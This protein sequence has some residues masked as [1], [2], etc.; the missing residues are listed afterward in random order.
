M[1][2]IAE[3]AEGAGI[4]PDEIDLYGRYK[5]KIHLA[6]L[7]R[8]ADKPDGNLILVTGITPTTKGE[9]KTTISIGLAQALRRAGH[10]AIACLREPSLG[11]VFGMKGGATGGGKA[12]I[13]PHIDINLHFTGDFHAV[14]AAHNLL[15]AVVDN[16]L[17]HGNQLGL[18]PRRVTWRRA[19]DMNDRALISV[20]VG[21]GGSRRGVPRESGFDIT[22]ASEVMAVLCL[23]TGLDDLKQRLGRIV[24]GRT[25]GGDSVT[26]LDLKC[27]DAMTLLMRE[28]LMP[29]LVQDLEIGPTIVHGGPFA[30]IAHG[31]SSILGTRMGLKLADYVVTEAGFG[32]DL[33]AEKFFDIK[34]RS[35]SLSPKV[36]VMIATVRALKR[37]GGV[38]AAKLDQEDV[39]AVKRGLPNL[40][41]HVENMGKFGMKTVIA[42]NRFP[43][44]SD[45]EV[46]AVLEECESEG[47]AGAVTD[48]FEQGSAGGTDLAKAVTD[49]VKS[50]E[51]DFH[52]LYPLDLPVREKIETIAAEVYGADTVNFTAAAR[53]TLRRLEKEGYG[54]LPVCI[55]KTQYSL[56]DKPRVVGR[57]EGFS[58]SVREIRLSAGAGFVVALTGETLTMPGLPPHPASEGMTI[59]ADGTVSGLV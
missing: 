50:G 34:C 27:Q 39:E 1:K 17:H 16:H 3:I 33:G 21:L 24:V 20:I 56:S 58:I 18:D 10:S 8:L 12:R 42:M 54:E 19:I 9:G 47:L 5:A 4:L 30:N 52:P 25:F 7:D 53:R 51:S 11:P 40:R 41:K 43:S 44:D 36:V 48:V 28:A 26:V 46:A 22:P 55:A 57:P 49:S 37:H 32:A 59:S 15:S 31:C 14:T 23:S 13:V 2:P 45:A 6:V 29:N 38:K 35:G